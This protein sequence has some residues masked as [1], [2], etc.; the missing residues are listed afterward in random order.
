VEETGDNRLAALIGEIQQA[1]RNYKRAAL[2]TAEYYLEVGKLLLEAKAL[3]GHGRFGGF[4]R[5]N[6]AFSERSAENYMRVASSGLKSA[7]VAEIGLRGAVDAV[8]A[9]TFYSEHPEFAEAF[10][11]AKQRAAK[12][13]RMRRDQR[14]GRLPL[15]TRLSHEAQA[16]AER[17]ARGTLRQQAA[18]AGMVPIER[19]KDRQVVQLKRQDGERV[20]VTYLWKEMFDEFDPRAFLWI[21]VKIDGVNAAPTRMT[22][23]DAAN[24]LGDVSPGLSSGLIH[25]ENSTQEI[26]DA[27]FPLLQVLEDWRQQVL[28]SRPV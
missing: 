27:D 2:Q 13:A 11:N 1:H 22:W 14:L 12:A 9:T 20:R 23:E 19:P 6:F 18:A 15:R 4:I 16:R 17:Q 24:Q 28:N 10:P 8:W 5:K 25:L 21:D 26:W 7:T 3:L